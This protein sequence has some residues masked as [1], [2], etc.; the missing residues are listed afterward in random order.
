MTPKRKLAALLAAAGL[1]AGLVLAGP[2]TAR[3]TDVPPDGQWAEIYNPYLHAQG[4]ILCFDDPS[5]STADGTQAQLY[6][7]HGCA[8]DGTPQR[9]VFIQPGQP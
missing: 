9:W 4:N 5:G 2:G 8:S 3:A 6:R 7:C 1:A